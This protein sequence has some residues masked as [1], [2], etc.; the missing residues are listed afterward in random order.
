MITLVQ[1]PSLKLISQ[2]GEDER[3]F[4]I[5]AGQAAREKRDEIVE[6]EISSGDKD[7]V[8]KRQQALMN[9]RFLDITPEAIEL[10]ERWIDQNAI[11]L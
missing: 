1:S 7:A 10:A 4:R 9:G 2:P 11:P 6:Q 8:S 3:D 5:R